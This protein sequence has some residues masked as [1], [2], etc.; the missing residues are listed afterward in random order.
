MKYQSL[1][2]YVTKTYGHKL[3]KVSIDGG[4]TCP[5][6]DGTIGTG[7]CIFCLDGSGAFAQNRKES[8]T[9]QIENGKKLI[10]AK[11]GKNA[12]YIAYFQSFT[13]TYGPIDDLR[14]KYMEAVLNPDTEVISIATRPDCVNPEVLNL[15][16]EINQIKPVWVELGLQTIHETT[17]EVIRR[18]YSLDVYKEAVEALN[19]LGIKVITHMIIGLPGESSDMIV[20]TARYIGQS[21][22]WGIKFQ[23]LHILEGTELA[24]MYDRGEFNALTLEE[25]ADILVE[26]LRVIP[27]SMV[28]HRITGDGDKKHLIAPLWSG[29]KK[30]VLNYLNKRILEANK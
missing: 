3:Y 13:G 14:S 27:D 23:L 2:E 25:Y 19:N 30:Y 5:N 18:G 16:N 11:A 9:T 20:E 4:F 28:V 15:L 8:I 10:E 17:A 1:S 6:R 26:C 24:S 29:N 7:G 21:G 12:K 22:S